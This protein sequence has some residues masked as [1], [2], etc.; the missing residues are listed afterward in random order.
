MRW[1]PDHDS[2]LFLGVNLLS[3]EGNSQTGFRKVIHMSGCSSRLLITFPE[4]RVLHQ[5]LFLFTVAVTGW[6]TNAWKRRTVQ[7]VEQPELEEEN[8]DMRSFP[9]RIVP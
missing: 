8:M 2:M 7:P 4:F 6:T 9:L 1:T 3:R 5:H